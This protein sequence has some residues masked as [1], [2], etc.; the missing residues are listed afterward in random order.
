MTHP[1]LAGMTDYSQIYRGVADVLRGSDLSFANL[2]FPVDST[3]P[4]TGYPLFNAHQDYVQAAADAGINVFSM[5]N[6]HAFDGGAPATGVSRSRT[7]SIPRR[8]CSACG[9]RAPGT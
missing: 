5:A 2:E 3:R 6:N 9:T 4:S 7:R 8:K 1:A